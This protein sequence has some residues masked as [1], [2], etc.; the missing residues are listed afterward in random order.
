MKYSNS[1]RAIL[2]INTGNNP[3]FREQEWI[4]ILSRP[5]MLSF[6]TLTWSICP[7]L[8]SNANPP[9]FR[10]RLLIFIL[11]WKAIARDIT[12]NFTNSLCV[13]VGVYSNLVRFSLFGSPLKICKSNYWN[14]TWVKDAIGIHFYVIKAKGHILSPRVIWG[15]VTW[16]MEILLFFF[17]FFF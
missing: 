7:G 8:S 15:Q 3:E 6:E 9:Y 12:A 4:L 13:Y 2:N 14:Q 16:K 1:K 10:G 5:A 17:F 11:T